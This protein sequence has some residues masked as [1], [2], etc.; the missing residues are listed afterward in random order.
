MS[1]KQHKKPLR[2][3]IADDHLVVR[4]GLS[5]LISLNP[6]MSVVG[7][8]EDGESAAEL[9]RRHHP[10][11]VVMDVMMPRMNGVEATERI[12][13]EF[14]ESR[15][16]LLTTFSAS[17]EVVQA[18]DAG[19][20]GAIVKDSSQQELIAAIKAVAA[21][22]RVISPEI[23]RTIAGVS[24][25]PHLSERHR[26]ILKYVTKGLSNPEIGKLLGIGSDCV[27]AHLKVAYSR[28]GVATRTEAVA[29]VLRENLLA[30]PN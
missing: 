24:Q 16:L 4:M 23:S 22:K 25:K 3:L 20:C 10:D 30:D 7:E 17:S 15:I 12:A 13:A 26:T 19:A 18:L 14:P 5:A 2:V 1:E 29:I 8:A 28:L 27:K 6:E 11:V 21:G 9:V